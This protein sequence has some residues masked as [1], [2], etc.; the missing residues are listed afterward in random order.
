MRFRSRKRE[1]MYR[2]RRPLVAALLAERPICERCG[3]NPSDDVHE[4]VSRARGGSILDTSN[5]VCLCRSCHRWLTDHP[6][7]AVDEGFSA[8]SW[9][10]DRY[11]T[12]QEG[13]P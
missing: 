7:A 1:A 8:H 11:T 3:T 6:A 2:Q 13:M 4:V 10:R 5:L 9:D 12:D